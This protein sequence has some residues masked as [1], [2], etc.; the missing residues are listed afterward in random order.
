MIA[1]PTTATYSDAAL[2]VY[3]ERFPLIDAF[4]RSPYRANASGLVMEVNPFWTAAYDLNSAASQL[5]G[6]KAS[7]LAAKYDFSTDGQSFQRSQQMAHAEQRA[8]YYAARRSPGTITLTPTP[9]LEQNTDD[10]IVEA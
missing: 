2:A 8:R 7:G 5:W 3:I 4:G 6:E 1:E 9:L 10:E